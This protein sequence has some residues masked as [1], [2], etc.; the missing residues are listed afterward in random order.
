MKKSRERCLSP[1]EIFFKL[2]SRP[3]RDLL[4]LVGPKL[5]ISSCLTVQPGLGAVGVKA[6]AKGREQGR[7]TS[8][9]SPPFASLYPIHT[10]SSPDNPWCSYSSWARARSE[11]L[12]NNPRCAPALRHAS[13]PACH[14][15]ALGV[16]HQHTPETTSSTPP[17]QRAGTQLPVLPPCALLA[18]YAMAVPGAQRHEKTPKLAPAVELPL[19]GQSVQAWATASKNLPLEPETH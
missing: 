18:L 4:S 5:L 3:A 14:P 11:S 17:L 15:P 1:S 6:K 13:S 9:Y 8:L 12:L 2:L 10:A 7:E 19:E 16:Y